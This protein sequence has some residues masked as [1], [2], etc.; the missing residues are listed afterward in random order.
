[1]AAAGVLRQPDIAYAPDFNQYQARSKKR[2]TVENLP[3]TLPPGFPEKLDSSLVWEGKDVEQREDW[4]VKLGDNQLDEIDQALRHFKCRS[5]T[6]AKDIAPVIALLISSQSVEHIPRAYQQNNFSIAIYWPA[7]ARAIK[8]TALWK[9]VLRPA[10]LE[11]RLLL[12]RRQHHHLCWN[13]CLHRRHPW[14]STGSAP[15]EW[16]F[17]GPLTYQGPEQH[18]REGL[19]WCSLQHERQAGLPH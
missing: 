18:R 12:P 4:I 7:L 9:R 17:I 11:N 3:T 15:F 8:G 1:M 13:Q 19:H 5:T 10:W 6:Y 2:Q 16:H 14:T